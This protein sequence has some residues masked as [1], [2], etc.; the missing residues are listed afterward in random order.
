[1]KS[2]LTFLLAAFSL[3]AIGAEKPNIVLLVADDLNPFYL[4]YA[5]DPDAKT[6]NLDALAEESTNFTRCY[7]ASPV[8]MSARTSLVTGLF[9]HST[10]CWGNSSEL[11]VP[12]GLTNLFRD[13]SDAGYATTVVGKSHWYSG[14]G[15]KREFES[16]RDY[17]EGLGIDH[18]LDI[19]TTF[20]SRNGDGIYQ[21][22]LRSIGKFEAQ[23]EDLTERLRENQYVAR[24]SL[25]EPEESCDWMMT[26][27]AIDAIQNTPE[28]QPFFLYVGYSN[29]HSPFDPAGEFA[30]LHVPETLTLRKNVEP[31]EKYGTEYDLSEI[32]KTRT[33][34]LGKVAFLDSL[35]GRVVGDLK[36]AGLWENT[37]FVFTADHG[38]TV[39]EHRNISK[40]KF[41]EEVARVPLLVRTPGSTG[42][43][44]DSLC[45]L[46][47]LNPTLVDLAGGEVSPHVSGK[48]LVPV[49]KDPTATIRDAAFCEISNG[50]DFNYMVR[51]E[52]YKWFV[53]KEREH[54][55]DLEK[56]PFEM[57]NLIGSEA[58]A[59]E[60][61][62]LRERLRK[63]L[64]TEQLDYSAGY[65]PLADRVKNAKRS[66]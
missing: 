50:D 33:A 3:S 42:T 4:G 43:I 16:Q 61:D 44:S 10:G 21:D 41:W 15:F 52:R 24:P 18:F 47:D 31:F 28:D 38:M 5:G 65:V 54:L 57:K 9:P 26:D 59:P 34:Y 49:L 51:T 11:F 48:S 64:M 37:V 6:P 35:V 29:P 46:L 8:C 53:E 14:R 56:D 62:K 1:M 40:G 13:I 17:M 2:I 55:S 58:H 7:T 23:S 63:F 12:P 36:E 45:Q 20:G 22:Y 19:V 27:L 66:E 39:G 32:R 30:E 25:L 60:A